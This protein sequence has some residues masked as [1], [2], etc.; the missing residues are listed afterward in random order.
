M[1]PVV[2]SVRGRRRGPQTRDADF[3]A[4]TAHCAANTPS[5]FAGNRRPR[6]GRGG[7]MLKKTPLDYSLVRVFAGNIP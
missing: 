4:T 3:F 1:V 6:G 5:D 2:I 7:R